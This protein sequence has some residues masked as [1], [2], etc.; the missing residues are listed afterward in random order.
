MKNKYFY[1]R[2]NK[3]TNELS[4]IFFTDLYLQFHLQNFVFKGILRNGKMFLMFI[5]ELL[6][7]K[8]Q[9]ESARI[10]AVIK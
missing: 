8:S 3:E 10:I 6:D 5:F 9:F 7:I 2:F 4:S 1:Q